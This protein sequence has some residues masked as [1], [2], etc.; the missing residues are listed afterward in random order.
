[1]KKFLVLYMAP[2]SV[3]QEWMKKPE[4]ERKAA[5]QKMQA[6]WR[7][8]MGAHPTLA[9]D[10][11]GA[12]KTKRV[13]KEGVTDTKNDIMLYGIVEGESHQEIAD[14]FVGH[15]HFGIPEA[16]IEVMEV[17]PMGM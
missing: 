16:T 17:N 14:A 9:T 11:A 7:E 1:M 3:L 13:S 10:T 2:N 4:E 15:P 12:G 6:E 5:E 8:W